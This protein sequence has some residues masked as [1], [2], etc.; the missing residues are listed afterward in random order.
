L[1][2]KRSTIFLGLMLTGALAA[3]TLVSGE[4]AEQTEVAE[5]VVNHRDNV[6][7]RQAELQSLPLGRLVRDGVDEP[8]RDLFAG[9]TWYVP[10][11][12]PPPPPVPVVKVVVQEAP[13]PVAPPVPYNF[14][15][16]MRE[17]DGTEIAYLAEGDQV[18]SAKKGDI[19][20]DSY[21]VTSIS[22]K[23][24]ELV[25]LP[26]DIHETLA[27]GSAMGSTTSLVDSNALSMPP[28]A[29]MNTVRN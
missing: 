3:A 22:S 1:K 24:V 11:P 15:G 4:N 13:R 2:L 9:K 20:N 12:P 21:K 17:E 23:Q 6:E 27:A 16:L 8:A 7:I 29:I 26:L 14:I 25:Y 5:A 18:I 28:A 10:P 19:L